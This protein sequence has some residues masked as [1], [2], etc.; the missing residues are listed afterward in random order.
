MTAHPDHVA[1]QIPPCPHFEECGGCMLQHLDQKTYQGWKEA[2]VKAQF[3]KEK[4]V[5]AEWLPSVFIPSATRRRATLAALRRGT[6]VTLGFNAYRSDR[7]IDLSTCLLLTPRLDALRESLKP[8][9]ARLLPDGK[10]TDIGLQ[11]IDG[12]I[13]LVLTGSFGD[14]PPSK[15]QVV[16]EM[17]N[18]LDLARI[19]WRAKQFDP[20]ETLLELSPL[21]KT[22]GKLNVIIPP[23]AFLQPSEEGEAALCAAVMAGAKGKKFA[24]LFSGCG[25]FTGHLLAKGSVYAAESDR[26]ASAALQKLQSSR[27]TVERRDLFKEPVTVRELNNFDC[28]VFDPPR[29]GA[30]AQSELLARSKVPRVV[31]VSC[32]PQTFIRDAQ[33]LAAGGYV[34]QTVQLVDQFIWSAHSEVVGVFTR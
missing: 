13:E 29:A 4:V 14:L 19:G 16:A 8:F 7:I 22:F 17:L 25:T 28:V 12:A 18:T 1:T 21:K 32:C 6:D 5:P 31:G 26:P 20:A 3:E 11:E 33:I 24:D 23:G 10:V 2:D 34:L 27:L 30:K 9:L 15:M